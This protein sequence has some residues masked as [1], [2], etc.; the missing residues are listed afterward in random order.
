MVAFLLDSHKLNVYS[1]YMNNIRRA[2]P[3]GKA[4]LLSSLDFSQRLPFGFLT[5]ALRALS[6][7][8]ADALGYLGH[9]SI[10]TVLALDAAVAVL[11]I[12]PPT[13]AATS[14]EAPWSRA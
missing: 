2:R 6:G 9:F 13:S 14:Q 11:A 4:L 10:A 1:I 12:F 7:V 5:Q 3:A 8:S